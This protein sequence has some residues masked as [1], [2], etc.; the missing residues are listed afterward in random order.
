MRARWVLLV[1]AL[2]SLA[3]VGAWLRSPPVISAEVS[4]KPGAMARP[5][6]ASDAEG[7]RWEQLDESEM[8]PATKELHERFKELSGQ[9]IE[10]EDP[11]ETGDAALVPGSREMLGRLKPLAV[12]M[13]EARMAE[14]QALAGGGALP[15]RDIEPFFRLPFTYH[16]NEEC[17]HSKRELFAPVI[18]VAAQ[19]AL[20]GEA[21]AISVSFGVPGGS[22]DVIALFER[23]GGPY[24][25]SMVVSSGEIKTTREAISM[26]QLL[27][28][29]GL[30][31]TLVL[32]AY[33]GISQGTFFYPAHLRLFLPTREPARPDL[34]ASDDVEIAVNGEFELSVENGLILANF[35]GRNRLFP[36][37]EF[38]PLRPYNLVYAES[39]LIRRAFSHGVSRPEDLPDEWLRVPWNRHD[40]LFSQDPR[41]VDCLRERHRQLT[42]GD[43]LSGT[44]SVKRANKEVRLSLASPRVTFVVSDESPH[45]M[46]DVI[47]DGKG[48]RR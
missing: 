35:Y 33:R 2:A 23:D 19:R 9:H 6:A 8:A 48:C 3:G 39:D 30:F 27:I 40:G 21:V 15:E 34:R 14:A 7:A 41:V 28:T 36:R 20:E 16:D 26:S 42:A 17:N 29:P 5:K 11:D 46:L 25:L 4:A 13:L 31:G 45:D 12:S 22:D 47:V 24:R 37:D 18:G 43:G 32:V 1:A 10:L 38:A 44:L